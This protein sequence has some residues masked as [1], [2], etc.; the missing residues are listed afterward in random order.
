MP[1]VSV[2]LTL[3]ISPFGAVAADP[4]PQLSHLPGSDRVCRGVRRRMVD[5]EPVAVGAGDVR[6]RRFAE[7]ASVV[8]SQIHDLCH[9]DCGHDGSRPLGVLEPL[10]A[11]ETAGCS[12]PLR[13]SAPALVLVD[14]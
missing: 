14:I 12:L 1:S 4:Q 8:S 5:L 6:P 2:I 3:V 9:R 7:S 11:A 10:V 13:D